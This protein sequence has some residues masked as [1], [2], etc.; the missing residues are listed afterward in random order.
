MF[1]NSIYDALKNLPTNQNVCKFYDALTTQ[2][3][4]VNSLTAVVVPGVRILALSF[5]KPDAV[6]NVLE[7]LYIQVT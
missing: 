6:I 3:S 2:G 4:T 5:E 1:V 7:K